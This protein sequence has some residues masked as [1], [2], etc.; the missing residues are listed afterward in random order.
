MLE[1]QTIN[2]KSSGFF[3]CLH[4]LA[5]TLSEPGF[6]DVKMWTCCRPW[7]SAAEW[8]SNLGFLNDVVGRCGHEDARREIGADSVLPAGNDLPRIFEAEQTGQRDFHFAWTA[9]KV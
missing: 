1:L 6:D 3:D 8:R 7:F 4:A 9:E 2:T 5:E